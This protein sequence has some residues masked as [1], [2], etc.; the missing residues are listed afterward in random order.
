MPSCE[1]DRASIIEPSLPRENLYWTYDVGPFTK[2]V[3]RGLEMKDLRDLKDLVIDDVQPICH[4]RPPFQSFC[5][6]AQVLRTP[7]N[8]SR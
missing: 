1:S 4:H 7:P 5:A 2:G 8:E 6:G 3:R